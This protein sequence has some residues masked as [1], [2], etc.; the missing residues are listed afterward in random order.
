MSL[1]DTAPRKTGE[2]FFKQTTAVDK[3]VALHVGRGDDKIGAQHRVAWFGNE[4]EDGG[5]DTLSGENDLESIFQ[6]QETK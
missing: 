4:A 6:H 2:H 5:T 3:D 1:H